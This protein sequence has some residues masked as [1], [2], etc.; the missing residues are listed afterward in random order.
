AGLPL[1][2]RRNRLTGFLQRRGYDWG[3][4]SQ[5]LSKIIAGPES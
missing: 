1:D 5:V 4:I 3:T 2:K